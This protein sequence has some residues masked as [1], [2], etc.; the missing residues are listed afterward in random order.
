MLAGFSSSFIAD[1]AFLRLSQQIFAADCVSSS[2]RAFMIGGWR[3]PFDILSFSI[4]FIFTPP[5]LSVS[6]FSHISL[7]D[8]SF[9]L[10]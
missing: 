2:Q 1:A 9:Q 5:F 7:S 8:S 4:T 10:Q 6:S 3:F